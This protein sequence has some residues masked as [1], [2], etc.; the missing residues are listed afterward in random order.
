[1]IGIEPHVPDEG[2]YPP[3]WFVWLRAHND[4]ELEAQCDAWGK[5]CPADDPEL[6]PDMVMEKWEAACDELDIR[7]EINK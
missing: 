6:N 4:A 7:K 5:W 1:M 2:D 3:E